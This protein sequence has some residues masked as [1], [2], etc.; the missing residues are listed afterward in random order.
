MSF[1]TQIVACTTWVASLFV[2]IVWTRS[3]ASWQPQPA[4][5]KG[6][7]ASY[8]LLGLYIFV[9]CVFGNFER[10]AGD[11][12][13]QGLDTQNQIQIAVS[14]SAIAWAGWLLWT[15]AIRPSSFV[16]GINLWIGLSLLLWG[17]S[18]FWSVWPMMT[19]FRTIELGALWVLSMHLFSGRQPLARLTWWLL[20]WAIL[21]FSSPL[22]YLAQHPGIDI[23]QVYVKV[24]LDDA[25]MVCGALILIILYRLVVAGDMRSVIFFLPAAALFAWF[26]SLTSFVAL[27][28]GTLTLLICR[29]GRPF[30]KAA[31]LLTIVFVLPLV[32]FLL[33]SLLY[34]NPDTAAWVAWATG[35]HARDIEN[36]TGRG[37][38]W[39]R[40]FALAKDNKFGYGFAAAERLLYHLL[41]NAQALNRVTN[42]HNGF[43]AAWLAAGWPGLWAVVFLVAATVHRAVRSG[44][45]DCAFTLPIIVFVIV[46]NMTYTGVGG[47]LFNIEWF[48]VMVLACAGP[49]TRR[50]AGNLGDLYRLSRIRPI[51][52]AAG[53]QRA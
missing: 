2:F 26:S 40:L 32:A 49:V 30:G 13:T 17:L 23:S 16:A 44:Y 51:P 20:A 11:L 25:G 31:Q 43:V 53:G 52:R 48:L 28:F 41:Y 7:V 24:R 27:F 4:T 29:L 6:T 14:L 5:E 8:V 50:P 9:P 1:S 12:A 36:A 18:T 46:N 22:S 37:E 42:A 35:K 47:G 33:Y 39:E 10:K 21:F 34:N 15:R 45:K 38:L 19:A 3:L